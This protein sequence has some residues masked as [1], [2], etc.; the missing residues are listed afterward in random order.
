MWD[1]LEAA[2][3]DWATSSVMMIMCF[4]ITW[5]LYELVYLVLC[6]CNFVR[7]ALLIWECQSCCKEPLNLLCSSG[8]AKQ[9][10]VDLY[11]YHCHRISTSSHA[12]VSFCCMWF[13]CQT[14]ALCDEIVYTIEP[15]G[16][17][18]RRNG[19]EIW[20]YGSRH[21]PER[22]YEFYM[23][24]D[25]HSSTNCRHCSSSPKQFAHKLTLFSVH[26]LCATTHPD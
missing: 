9:N 19:A 23:H 24:P 25:K 10:L 22:T 16:I 6:S 17:L 26:L 18:S 8:C 13:N 1:M 7:H 21:T 12:T 20:L 4:W 11:H 14:H 15:S 3:L 2:F 5:E